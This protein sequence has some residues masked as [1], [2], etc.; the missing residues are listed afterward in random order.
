MNFC[1]HQEQTL[2]R[3]A[4]PFVFFI[5]FWAST[6]PAGTVNAENPAPRPFAAAV[7]KQIEMSVPLRTNLAAQPA[8]PAEVQQK[9][10]AGRKTEECLP[11]EVLPPE[12]VRL[13]TSA[14]VQQS[15]AELS[16]LEKI[17]SSAEK[18]AENPQPQSSH[19]AG[20][21]QFGYNFFRPAAPG[22]S[23][24]TDVP[25]G[26]DYPVGPGDRIIVNLWGSVE[27]THEL[28]VN[29]NG[30][31]FLPRVGG[32]KV[33]GVTFG[34]LHGVI[35]SSLAKAYKDFDLNVTMGKLRI[36]KVYVVGEVTAP[37]DYNLTPL[38]TLINALGAAGGPLKSG[39]LRNIKIKRGGTTV[40]T[41]DLYDFF[42]TGDKSRD[43]RLQ[44]GDTIF[45]P[46]IGPA[47]GIAGNV[48]RAAIYEF[49]DEKTLADLLSLAGGINP[50]GYLQ[51]IQIARVE[52]HEKRIISDFSLDPKNAGKPNEDL[53]GSIKLQDLD[54]VR[55]FPID[56]TLRGYVR[57]DGHVLRPGD[58]ALKPD[59]RIADLIGRDNLLQDHYANAAMLTRLSAPDYQ[60]E[61]LFINLEKALS[62]DTAHNLSLQEFDVLRIYSRRDMEETPYV[63]VS[64]EIQR[65]GR[66]QLTKNQ[67]V[68][69]LV[70]EAGNLKKIAFT[71]KAEI[72]RVKVDG[73][74]LKP[75]SIYIDLDEALKGNPQHNIAL[76]PLDEL[77]I[78]KYDMDETRV[79]R[80]NGEVHRPGEYRL[81]DKMTI[82]DLVMEAGGL[83]K[84]AYNR[85]AEITRITLQGDSVTSH[86]VN[87]DL[88]K[89]LKGDSAENLP[90]LQQDTVII[91]HIPNWIEETERYVTLKGEF[92]FP[93][94]Y[95]V[96]KGERLASVIARAGGFSERAYLRGAK[97]T[98]VSI[99]EIQQKRMNEV[100]VKAEQ[101]I[102]KKQSELANV[103]SSKEE[104]E[105]TRTA[106]DGLKRT[107]DML[108]TAEAEGRLVIRLDQPEIFVNSSYNVV[109]Q[110]GDVLEVPP[111]PSSVNVLGQVYNPIGL[112]PVNNEDV[113][114][115]LAKAGGPTTDANESD[116]FVVKIDGTVI[117]RQQSSFISSLFFNGFMSETMEPGDTIVVPQD[118]EK[119]AWM[120]EIKEITT[121]LG[122][123]ALSAGVLIAAGL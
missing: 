107:V 108:K 115:Y 14:N 117:S 20:L 27:G 54:L 24:L 7:P 76:N 53:T 94:V 118:F 57:L 32:I 56:S 106:L 104:L 101:D 96:V 93:G 64:G 67:T 99:K 68:S 44:T 71:K 63:S 85:K 40:E 91:R 1:P 90:L 60:P 100:I 61:K 86:T 84:T 72:R 45:V 102:L 51:R 8:S 48:R 19:G 73:D 39:T 37:G 113:A 92:Q 5:C 77:V 79:V 95:P 78:K 11:P 110:G 111:V 17:I 109:V 35:K 50:T 83:K 122:Q 123:I 75:Y 112:V 16:H 28:E 21:S 105:A 120:R 58:Y 55:I 22:F 2:S 65:P 97:F 103:A 4:L 114:Y 15:P 34:K 29:R 42:L 88:E 62:G 116:I 121:I 74:L 87:I 18:G 3:K 81:V 6:V 31:I 89:A 98:R 119:I 12:Q 49:K 52:A 30:E 23:P 70:K 36:I 66:Y 43:I 13:P 46:S 38:S 26:T 10:E 41:V 69:D 33:W 25:V 82:A 9:G 59:M 47:V 80:I